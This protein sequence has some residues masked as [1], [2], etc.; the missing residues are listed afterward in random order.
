MACPAGFGAQPGEKTNLPNIIDCASGV[1]LAHPRLP[2]DIAL[3]RA[4]WQ[5]S[6]ISALLVQSYIIC[7]RGEPFWALPMRVASG[8]CQDLWRA[9]IKA[10]L[11]LGVV[12]LLPEAAHGMLLCDI[13]SRALSLAAKEGALVAAVHMPSV[14]VPPMVV[15]HT[16][17]F[18]ATETFDALRIGTVRLSL[19]LNSNADFQRGMGLSDSELAEIN[20]EF[21]DTF[22]QRLPLNAKASALSVLLGAAMAAVGTAMAPGTGTSVFAFFG[23]TILYFII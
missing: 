11:Q 1:G 21:T 6:A 12:C 15:S 20:K 13:S 19:A 23:E 17:T 8:F 4:Q 16:A 7:K 5:E 9:T 2:L 3:K 18:L 10:Y 22:Y 14:A